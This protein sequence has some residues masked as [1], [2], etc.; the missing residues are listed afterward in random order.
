MSKNLMADTGMAEDLLRSIVQMGCAEVHANTLYYKATSELEN[1]IVDVTDQNK[2]QAHLEKLDMFREDIEHYADIRRLMMRSLFD[3]F[4]NEKK[5]KTMWCQ[6]KHL[7]TS[8]YCAFETYQASEQ[9]AELLSIAYEANKAFVK[10]VT[11]FLGREIGDCAS[12][13]TDA[14]KGEM[15]DDKEENEL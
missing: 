2:L 3:M 9:D 11:R 14:L 4:D 10:A 8:A 7:G 12:C 15:Q 1:G 13:L 5:D 6:I